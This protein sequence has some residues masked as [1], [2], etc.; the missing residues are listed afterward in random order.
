[1]PI[2]SSLESIIAA[3][4]RRFRYVRDLDGLLSRDSRFA[5]VCTDDDIRFHQIYQDQS[6]NSFIKGV[7]YELAYHMGLMLQRYLGGG[8]QVLAAEGNS[9]QFFRHEE[10]NH[11][12]LLLAPDA[13]PENVLL[14]DPSF[15]AVGRLDDHELAGYRIKNIFELEQIDPARNGDEVLTFSTLADGTKVTGSMPL[16][17]SEYLLPAASGIEPGL[18]VVMG[19]S[20]PLDQSIPELLL[21]IKRP[22]ERMPQ[23]VEN[24]ARDLPKDSPLARFVHKIETDLAASLAP[25][26]LRKAG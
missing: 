8:Y 11:I 6:R 17:F 5:A 22:D 10:A 24:L 25:A 26:A 7:C 20:W 12:F 14:I 21:G 23:I 16:G 4:F 18:L 2:E 19:F 9:P 13:N 3:F 15:G 1:M